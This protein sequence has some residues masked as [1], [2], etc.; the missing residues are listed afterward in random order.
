MRAT[1][2]K[3][4]VIMGVAGSGKSTVGQ[5]L[6]QQLGWR[7]IEGDDYHSPQAKQMMASGI[8]LADHLRESWVQALCNELSACKAA[9][10]PCVL[11]YSGLIAR[12]RQQIRS[13]ADN[14]HFFYLQGDATLL[15]QRL[16]QRQN[17]FMPAAMLQSQLLTMQSCDNETDITILDITLPAEKLVQQITRFLAA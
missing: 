10:Q 6:A 7:F 11:S 4:I 14:A 2:S 9:K 5:L 3:T 8:P 12:H 16:A 15:A 13:S 1:V 17:H